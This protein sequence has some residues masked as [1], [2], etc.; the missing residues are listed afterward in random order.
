MPRYFK[1]PEETDATKSTAEELEKVALFE[2]FLGRK[3]HLGTGLHP[4]LMSGFFE[5]LKFNAECFAWSHEDMTGILVE[6]AVHKLSLDPNVPPVRQKKRPIVEARNKFVKEEV[7]RL[8]NI[9]SI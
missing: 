4:E 2:E 3:F 6:V 5:F 1:V 8:L 7:I 9:G